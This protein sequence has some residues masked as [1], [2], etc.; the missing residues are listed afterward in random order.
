MAALWVIHHHA[1]EVRGS[2]HLWNVGKLLPDYKAPW[3]P[4]ISQMTN[5]PHCATSNNTHASLATRLLYDALNESRHTYLSVK[6]QHIPESYVSF[7]PGKSSCWDTYSRSASQQISSLLWKQEIQ[8]HCSDEHATR[9]PKQCKTANNPLRHGRDMT[10]GK[11][12]AVWPP[13]IH[14]FI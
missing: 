13:L 12:Q 6:Y 8:L 14:S 2:K 10:S 4:E 1:E 9:L 5:C 7:S 3:E 11:R